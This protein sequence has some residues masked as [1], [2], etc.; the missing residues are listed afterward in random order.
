MKK[1]LVVTFSLLI[2]CSV[3][4]FGGCAN[5]NTDKTYSLVVPDGAPAMAVAS[6]LADNVVNGTKVVTTITTGQDAQSKV[7]SGQA[8]L[9]IL[10]TNLAANLYNKGS[11]YKLVT[12]N[13]YGLLYLVASQDMSLA[14]LQGKVVAS[15]GKSNTPEYV[16]KKILSDNN[17][18]YADGDVAQSGVVTIRYYTS[19]AEILPLL[20]S[21]E[22]ECALIGEP[23]VSKALSA[24]TSLRIVADLQQLWGNSSHGAEG[25]PQAG[26]VVS[27]K[28]L[29]ENSA[30]V[31]SLVQRLMGNNQYMLDNADKLGKLFEEGGSQELSSVAFDKTLIQRCNLNTVTAKDAYNGLVQYFETLYNFNAASVGNKMPDNSFYYGL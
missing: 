28:L 16:F 26:L 7:L 10:P 9:A 17:I 29:D 12:V 20:L 27:Q 30:F 14:D 19:A 8:D 3:L 22:I 2:L 31:D 5:T 25:Y 4:L 13:V 1:I 6:L 18:P 11:G 23:A 24:N 21:G 15:I